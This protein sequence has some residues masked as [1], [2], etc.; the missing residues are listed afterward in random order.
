M[1]TLMAQVEKRDWKLRFLLVKRGER[2]PMRLL[3]K[4]GWNQREFTS[5]SSNLREKILNFEEFCCLRVVFGDIREMKKVIVCLSV[6]RKNEFGWIRA[7]L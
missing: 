4:G 3:F 5:F 1:Y 2:V 6:V 7:Y